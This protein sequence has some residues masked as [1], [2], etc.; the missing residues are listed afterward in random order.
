MQLGGIAESQPGFITGLWK[1]LIFALID[2][3]KTQLCTRLGRHHVSFSA[4]SLDN[5]TPRTLLGVRMVHLVIVDKWSQL[6]GLVVS[7]IRSA[8]SQS[9][10]YYRTI[11]A[12]A[13]KAETDLLF[14]FLRFQAF[15][16]PNE[17]FFH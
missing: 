16:I 5:Q 12:Q 8:A 3:G 10:Y 4:L 9:C 17:F 15:L 14:F 1:G 13:R 6:L 11:R 2:T 7:V